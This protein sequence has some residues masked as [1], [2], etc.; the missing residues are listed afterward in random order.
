MKFVSGVVATIVTYTVIGAGLV[1]GTKIAQTMYENG[2][3][4]KVK[5]ASNKLFHRK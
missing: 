3:E 4:D 1:L 2:L 5:N